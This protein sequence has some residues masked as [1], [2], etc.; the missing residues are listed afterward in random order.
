MKAINRL[1]KIQANALVNV[2]ISCYHVY[3][4]RTDKGFVAY[5]ND[6][7]AGEYDN[8]NLVLCPCMYYHEWEVRERFRELL[9]DEERTIAGS[10]P[11]RKGYFKYLEETGLI[12]KYLEA[13]NYITVKVFEEWLSKNDI[14]LDWNNIVLL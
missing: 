5:E 1:E 4:N 9:T 2:D 11:F 14:Q 8:G 6:S 3:Y 10:Y 7:L 12:Y 13:E